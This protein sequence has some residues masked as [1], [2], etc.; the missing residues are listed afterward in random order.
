MSAHGPSTQPLAA[1]AAPADTIF[2]TETGAPGIDRNAVVTWR[3]YQVNPVVVTTN[4]PPTL[5]TNQGI[6][7]YLR[8]SLGANSTFCDGH[9]RWYRG[10]NLVATH[11]VGPNK[12]P[13][14]YLWTI[15][16]D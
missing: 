11:P 12:I 10:S 16:D 8:H 2:A 6:V 15:E 13:I 1:L 3:F 4:N 5:N 7:V 14:C 9:S